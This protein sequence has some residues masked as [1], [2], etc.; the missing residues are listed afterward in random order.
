[1]SESAESVATR[2][3]IEEINGARLHYE[4]AGEGPA[5]VFLHAGIADGRMWDGQFAAFAR[6]F[7][8]VRY[9]A[10]GYGRSDF[11]PGP[12]ARHEDL[13]GLVRRLGV[14]RA[15]LVGCSMGG[16][17]AIDFALEHPE[18]ASAL[19]L[20]GPGLSGYEQWSETMKAND[21]AEEAAFARA[22]L[23]AV[24]E[25]SLRFWVDGPRRSPDQ[26]DPVVRE[27]VRTMLRDASTSTEGQPRRLDPPAIGRLAEIRAPTLVITGGEDVADMAAIADL[28]VGAIPGARTATITDAAHLPNMEQPA[29]FNRIVLDFLDGLPD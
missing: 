27:A 6:R 17:T 22:D 11:P 26:V 23:D 25:M 4:V 24:I 14:E 1:M 8:V 21:E 28:L 29:L 19:V 7:R 2:V 5:L 12:F 15:A 9:D 16:A 18:M 3:G 10:R 20:V 13:Y